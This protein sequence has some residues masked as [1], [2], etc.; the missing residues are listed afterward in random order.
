MNEAEAG[1]EK[2]RPDSLRKTKNL[3]KICKGQAWRPIPGFTTFEQ[4]A[5]LG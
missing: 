1:P 4:I 3:Q 2:F 5:A